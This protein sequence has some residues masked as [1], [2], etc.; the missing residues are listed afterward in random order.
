MKKS[1]SI[2]LRSQVLRKFML[3][4]DKVKKKIKKILY[5]EPNYG[6]S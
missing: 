5:H 6:N 2:S 1:Y 3:N 4:S